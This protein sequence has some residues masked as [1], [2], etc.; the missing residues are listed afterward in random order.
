MSLFITIG[1]LVEKSAQNEAIGCQVSPFIY[2]AFF[3]GV[4]A[5]ATNFNFK[6]ITCANVSISFINDNYFA[7]SENVAYKKIVLRNILN[8]ETKNYYFDVINEQQTEYLSLTDSSVNDKQLKALFLKKDFTRLKHLNLSGNQIE[9]IDSDLFNKSVRIK[10]LII[11]RNEIRHLSGDVFRALENLKK[12]DLS[13]NKIADLSRSYEIFSNLRDLTELDL[14]NNNINDIPRHLFYGLGNL[15]YLNMANNNFYVLPYQPFESM[16]SV[17]VIDLSHNSLNSF[18]PNFFVHN[19]KLKILDLQY[20]LLLRIDKNSLYGLRELHTLDLSHNRMKSIDRNA[21]DTLDGLKF[22]N[23]SFNHIEELS[24]I[25]FLSLK[26]LA[27]LD[28]SHNEL[29][30]LPI[31][32]F[33]NQFQMQEVFIENTKIKKLS[34]WIS[35]DNL[36]STINKRT[37]HN[38]KIVSLRNSTQ[39]ESVESSFFLNLPNVE[40]LYITFSSLVTFLPKGINEMTQ[41][42]DLDVSNNRLQFIPEDIKHLQ[43]LKRLNLLHNDLHCDCHMFWMLGWIDELKLKNKTLPYDLLRLSE[44]KC[45]NGYPGE[46][47]IILFY[48]FDLEN[49]LI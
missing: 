44:L 30:Q 22:L 5:T 32:I 29:F 42:V 12:L 15:V 11:A 39:L 16:R 27:I 19:T 7:H 21:F 48:F 46:I 34:N 4:P 24:Q 37:L 28:L 40:R 36:N 47:F 23:L 26:Q 13:G 35:R 17:E 2:S 20:N 49:L 41:L 31:G 8:D 6:V 10:E 1:T 14:S 3:D 33:A 45:R 43:N 38:L 25:V 18:L 9:T